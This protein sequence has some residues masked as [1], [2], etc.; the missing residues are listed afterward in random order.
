[1]TIPT[2]VEPIPGGFRASTG[3]PLV[4]TADGPTADAA[5]D[6]VQHLVNDRLSGGAVIRP[7]QVPA[8]PRPPLPPHVWADFAA[9]IRQYREEREA[10]ELA[11]EAAGQ[12]GGT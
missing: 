7:V 4:L 6:A 5:V 2:L 3:G 12:S 8:T 10:E 1:M 9:A 11:A